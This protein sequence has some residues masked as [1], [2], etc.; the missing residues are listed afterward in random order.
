ME[1]ELYSKD[2]VIE[3]AMKHE[4]LNHEFSKTSLEKRL[5]TI[6]DFLNEERVQKVLGQQIT[7]KD[8]GNYFYNKEMN[9]TRAKFEKTVYDGYNYNVITAIFLASLV[10]LFEQPLFKK[11]RNQAKIKQADK[12]ENKWMEKSVTKLREFENFWSEKG[13]GREWGTIVLNIESLFYRLTLLPDM[14]NY[15]AEL[16]I[17]LKSILDSFDA[18]SD[19]H[20]VAF[21]EKVMKNRITKIKIELELYI[22]DLKQNNPDDYYHYKSNQLLNEIDKN[23]D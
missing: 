6:L 22:K 18:L 5:N 10:C 2:K 4:E 15:A 7:K 21:Y 20:K 23:Y 16:Q 11:L 8:V 14:S 3:I 12:E 13:D 17:K 9:V 1:K 19:Q